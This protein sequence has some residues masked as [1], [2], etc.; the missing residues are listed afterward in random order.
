M[1]VDDLNFEAD[2]GVDALPIL[3]LT[4]TLT[5]RNMSVRFAAFM[6]VEN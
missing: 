5:S 1:Y 2:A 6:M 3:A 4:V